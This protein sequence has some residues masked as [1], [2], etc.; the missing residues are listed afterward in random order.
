MKKVSNA[1]KEAMDK[2]I[3]EQG[4]ISVV[5]AE[6]NGIAQREASFLTEGAYWSNGQTPFDNE[7]QIV[8]YA[9]FENGY[10]RADGLS[11]VMPREGGNIQNSGFTTEDLMQAI[12]ISFGNSYVIK[13][14]TIDFGEGY[15]TQFKISTDINPTGTTYNNDS[16]EFSTTD[17]LGEI[18]SITITPISMVGGDKRLRINHILMGVGLSYSNDDIESSELTEENSLISAELPS[19][20]FSVTIFDEDN[21]YNVNNPD[22]FINFLT[23]GQTVTVAYG[24]TLEDESIEW[25]KTQTLYLKNWAAKEGKFTFSANDKFND[26][27]DEYSLGYRVY[28]RTAYD[29]A[30]SILQDAGLQPGEYEI[31]NYLRDINLVN[32]MPKDTHSNC[33]KLLCN[34]TRCI[35][36]QD[37]SGIIKIRGYF[38]LSIQPDNIDITSNTATDY[39]NIRNLLTAD[40][41]TTHYAD[42]S[43][44]YSLADGGMSVLPTNSVQYD[45]N[46]G[47]VSSVVSDAN[48]DFATN[49]SITVELEA[50]FT[51]YSLFLNFSGQPPKEVVI[52]TFHNNVAVEDYTFNDLQK[53]NIL[54]DEFIMFDKMVVEFTKTTPY[55][56]VVVDYLG[57]GNL[58]DYYLDKGNMM[59]Q[60]VGSIETKIADVSVKI[61]SYTQDGDNEPEE[62]DDDVWYKHTIN[63]NGRHIEVT[64]PLI[65][66]AA[67]AQL[68]AEWLGLYYDNNYSYE[69]DYRGDPRLN[70]TDIIKIE[71]DYL[72]NLQAEITKATLTF[73]G[74][75]KGSLEMRKAVNEQ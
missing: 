41:V 40:S 12:T 16:A 67:Q 3:R 24:I 28:T 17:T 63:S 47:Y 21:K 43:A 49:P 51:Y 71:D 74:A 46:T 69:C 33:L 10:T 59:S 57:L 34:A 54:T 64:N 9:T 32:P 14:L 52:H 44:N 31:D 65:N 19:T 60:L 1:Y 45:G 35:M 5:L 6:V 56:R 18:S 15:P 55:S 25:L 61:Y 58:T 7:S 30:E 66:T 29:E 8:Q 39:S 48:G 38:A 72:N 22:S 27:N 13:G 75:F 20:E 36:V 11:L 23:G 4:F 73:N 2:D 37:K 70:A 42:F 68:L 26:L 50:G 53:E 62:V